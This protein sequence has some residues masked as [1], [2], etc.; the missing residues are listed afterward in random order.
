ME[1]IFKK[2][3]NHFNLNSKHILILGS[4]QHESLDAKQICAKTNIP[5]GRIYY[6]LNYLVEKQLVEKT[7]KKPFLYS[8]SNVNQ[9][10][11]GFMK[12][13]IDKMLQAQGEVMDMM[14]GP[15]LDHFERITDTKKFT[16]TH[17][18]MISESKEFFNYVSLHTSFPYVLYSFNDLNNF[19]KMREAIAK[20]RPTITFF[21][22]QIAI[23]VYK[24]YLAALEKG[25]KMRVVFEKQ[26]FDYHI[27]VI[28]KKLGKKFFEKW[29][30]EVLEQFD[31]YNIQA[32]V[33]EEYL[34][35]QI[36]INERRVNLVLR[37]LGI[38]NGMVIGSHEIT[39]LYTKIF[40]QTC[41]RAK[42]VLPLIKKLNF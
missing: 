20:S 16:E 14:K 25:I 22:T 21:D 29:K 28:K 7:T 40:A 12:Q 23:L 31:K 13:R 9:N 35:I 8:F 36:D 11:I 3:Q 10:I 18:N 19:I 33:L 37:H 5:Q 4:L 32:Y 41:Q 26:S 15:S 38:I 39:D 2:L 17:L 24:T 42:N 1:Q 34:P 30:K 27:K 6:Y